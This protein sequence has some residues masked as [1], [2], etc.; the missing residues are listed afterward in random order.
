MLYCD[1]STKYFTQ[2]QG[3]EAKPDEEKCPDGK[4][5]EENGDCLTENFP[6]GSVKDKNG[7]CPPEKCPDGKAKDK[8]GKCPSDGKIECI[9]GSCN[10]ST[11]G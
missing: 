4:S 1:K 6:G 11:K 8:D 9:S 5:K 7:K 3:V 10:E 2:T